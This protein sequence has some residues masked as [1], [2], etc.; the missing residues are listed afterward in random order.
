MRN[1]VRF[2]ILFSVLFLVAGTAFADGEKYSYVD[3]AKVF[4]G[5]QRTKDQDKILQDI[6]KKKEADRDVI[7]QDVRKMKD[8]IA[9]LAD[10]AKDKKQE[11]LDAKVSDLQSFDQ[12]AKQDLGEQRNKIVREIFKDI[13]AVVQK[14]GEKKGFDFVLN[15]RAL[16]YHNT[17]LD[18]TEEVLK[19]LNA[20]YVKKK[21]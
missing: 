17:R 9:L 2:S 5:Y 8:E 6:G 21:K 12:Q 4:D 7:V 15:E 11:A 3:I 19:E 20:E 1:T 18:S 13:D 10:D 16:L 14:F